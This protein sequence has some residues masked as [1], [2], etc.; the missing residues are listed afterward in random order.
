MAKP[1]GGDVLNTFTIITTDPNA[2]VRPIHN[3]M[4][5]IY[6]KEMGKQ[7][8]EHSF[9][10]RARTLA[11]VHPGYDLYEPKSAAC[12]LNISVS[13]LKDSVKN[14]PSGPVI[15]GWGLIAR[16]TPAL[17]VWWDRKRHHGTG[18]D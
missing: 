15:M 6:D 16:N 13:F 1:S 17:Q 8:L 5:V 10:D 18:R 3:R 9:G 2:L 4:P 7:W 12:Q 11:A 14:D